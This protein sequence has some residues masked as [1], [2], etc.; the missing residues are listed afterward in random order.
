MTALTTVA[1]AQHG[2][3]AGGH[4]GVAGHDGPPSVAANGRSHPD[5][6]A[7]TGSGGAANFE[8]RLAGNPNLSS[9]LQPLLPPNTTLGVAAAGFKNQGQFI[10]ALHVSHNLNVPFDQ[11]KTEMV[12]KHD[13]L[14]SAIRDLRPDLD[15]KAVSNNVKLAEH[16]AKTDL[17]ESNEPAETSG[18]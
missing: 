9:R 2:G 11:L 3:G 17:A 1:W 16:Q 14:G 6:K 8:S 15:S 5:S 10:A 7:T 18:K 13:S 12:T 4:G